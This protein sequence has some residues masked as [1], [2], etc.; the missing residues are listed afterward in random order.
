[1]NYYLMIYLSGFI[2]SF[3]IGLIMTFNDSDNYEDLLKGFAYTFVWSFFSWL[4]VIFVICIFTPI[5]ID[6]FLQKK[7]PWKKG[8][9]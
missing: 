5:S 1:M 2:V 7:L 3:I 8:K 4:F 9:E 6:K